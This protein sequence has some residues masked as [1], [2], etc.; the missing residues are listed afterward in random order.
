MTWVTVALV[1]LVYFKVRG[2]R[3]ALIIGAAILIL[4]QLVYP[5]F[6]IGLLGLD[7]LPLG[8]LTIRNLLLVALLVWANIRLAKRA[9]LAKSVDS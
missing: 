6:Y 4:T 5:V 1:A 8:L 9:S 7:I 2:A 3:T